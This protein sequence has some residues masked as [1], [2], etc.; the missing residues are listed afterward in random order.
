M[1][2]IVQLVLNLHGVAALAFVFAVPVIGDSVGY[3]R[4]IVT[5]HGHLEDAPDLYQRF[6]LRADGVIKAVLRP[7]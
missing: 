6:D 2:A 5:H 1:N 4:R 7:S 3:A